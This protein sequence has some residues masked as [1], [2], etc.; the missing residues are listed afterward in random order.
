VA[1]AAGHRDFLEVES[2]AGLLIE[3]LK[4]NR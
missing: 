3:H 1:L 2:V 4:V